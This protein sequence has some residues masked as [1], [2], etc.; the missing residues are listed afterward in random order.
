MVIQDL[1]PELLEL[2]FLKC[3]GQ[4]L[5]ITHVCTFWRDVALKIP[6]LWAS[7]TVAAS[8]AE[9]WPPVDEVLRRLQLSGNHPLTISLTCLRNP[10]T[11]NQSPNASGGIVQALE[12]FLQNLHRWKTVMFDFRLQPPP[13]NFPA[14][15]A[16]RGAPQLE[17][18][19]LYP[20]TWSPLLGSF[21]IPWLTTILTNLPQLAYFVAHSGQF[22]RSFFARTSWEALTR[23]KVAA[24][25]PEAAWTQILSTTTR[26]V[27]CELYN[28]GDRH[29]VVTAMPSESL[30]VLAHLQTLVLGSQVTFEPFFNAITAP[31]LHVLELG[32]R[33]QQMWWTPQTQLVAFLRRSLCPLTSLTIR[34]LYGRQGPHELKE[35]FERVGDT[36][37]ELR[38]TSDVSSRPELAKD[39]GH[40]NGVVQGNA[41]IHD[42]III[43]LAGGLLPQLEHLTVHIGAYSTDG[44][45]GRMVASRW[46]GQTRFAKLSRVEVVCEKGFL[47]HAQDIEILEALFRDGLQ[48]STL[49]VSR[50]KLEEFFQTHKRSGNPGLRPR[51]QRR[52]GK[53]GTGDM[54]FSL[55]LPTFTIPLQCS[56]MQA[57]STRTEVATTSA[58]SLVAI[59][60]LLRA[61]LGCITF[62][63]DLL[64]SENFTDSHF[65]SAED[66]FLSSQPSDANRSIDS[67]HGNSKNVNGFKIMTMTRGYTHEADKIL[68][69]LARLPISSPS[70]QDSLN[71]F[72]FA[73]YLVC[74]S[75]FLVCA[76]FSLTQA[77]LHK[78]EKDPNNIVEAYTFNF[79]YHTIPGTST[80][81]PL[82]SVGENKK[83][84][85]KDP[86]SL[87][88]KRGKA[89]TLKDVKKSTIL[90]TLIHSTTQMDVLPKR[91]FAAFKLFYTD[92]TPAEYEPPH[93]QAGDAQRDKWYF[94]THDMDEVPDNWKVGQVDTGHHAVNLSVASIAT[95]LP[96]S[97]ENDHATFTG[98]VSRSNA[99]PPPLTP[100]EEAAVRAEQ[101][102]KQAE[103]AE[104]RNVV[105]AADAAVEG[106]DMDCP[107]EDEETFQGKLRWDAEVGMVPIGIRNGDGL[108]EP[109]PV[110]LE[111]EKQFGGTSQLVPTRLDELNALGQFDNA[112]MEQT[113][114]FPGLPQ[115]QQARTIPLIDSLPPSDVLS[116]STIADILD[117]QID[118]DTQRL[119]ALALENQNIGDDDAEMLDME[120]QPD[121]IQSFDAEMEDRIQEDLPTPKPVKRK[122][123]R[124]EDRGLQCECDVT[125]EDDQCFCEDCGRWYH[126]WCM[127]FHSAQ[128][129]RLPED[130]VCFDCRVHADNSWEL[131]KVDL[132][133]KMLS[134]FKD[135]ALFRRAI[136]ISEMHNPPVVAEFAK[137]VGK[138]RSLV[139]F[140]PNSLVRGCD[141][142]LARQLFK[143]LE[144]E[145]FIMEHTLELDDLGF[146]ETRSKATNNKSKSKGKQTKQRKNVQ[147]TRYTFDY[148]CLKTERYTD[149]FDPAKESQLLDLPQKKEKPAVK[150]RRIPDS[151][152]EPEPQQ[153]LIPETQPI[154]D[155]SQTQDDTQMP[156][157]INIVAR[158]A[159]SKRTHS[160]SDSGAAPAPR[161]KKKVKI[162]IAPAVDLAE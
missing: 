104:N 72:I 44:V 35:I 88:A 32:T 65:T 57:Q 41:G 116:S 147:K 79:H 74:S 101:V 22:P 28:I 141:N 97:T 151:E 91:R 10:E 49:E 1:P 18:L 64:P 162:S 60:T 89:P 55:L 29:E 106:D 156:L 46:K 144:N 158:S 43:D 109:I 39:S 115:G 20:A 117:T 149:Y 37:V 23:L 78:D 12:L 17:Q 11:K 4:T 105:W 154:I 133:P 61:S 123:K 50:E 135:L 19:E 85:G 33:A 100:V 30:M 86:V 112:N 81:I 83:H 132:Y 68:N 25:L 24:R 103:D 96:S 9:S 13:I 73:I 70:Y 67:S 93:F 143:R 125:I 34:D 3:A 31:N 139:E 161:P 76:L 130:F 8:H 66:S 122:G 140:V 80:V 77:F 95:Y 6:A 152:P 127:G 120:T 7:I 48:G 157:D 40:F 108:I 51:G 98:T 107:G 113:Q 111:A 153:P 14:F 87:A 75:F 63:R 27:D 16:E 62:L 148:A 150:G 26:L 84:A 114:S 45:F 71:F 110:E 126:V 2:V 128:D 59:Q 142:I 36:L 121:P 47:P 102:A 145:G 54:T 82:M 134:N 138:P 52:Q 92:E 94:M 118:I 58:Q 131:I 119:Q 38:L 159:L 53:V 136:K 160:H 56:T 21:A 15:L 129:Q 42:R 146:L 5:K 99:A 137:L 155:D 124:V 90:K 69:Y